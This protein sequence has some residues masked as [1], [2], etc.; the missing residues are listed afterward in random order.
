MPILKIWKNDEFHLKNINLKE[1]ILENLPY[2]KSKSE[3]LIVFPSVSNLLRTEILYSSRNCKLPLEGYYR[4]TNG[5]KRI[6]IPGTILNLPDFHWYD[7]NPE[8]GKLSYIFAG[9][10]LTKLSIMNNGMDSC[11][12]Q[13][14]II[15]NAW[16]L[17][18]NI[19]ASY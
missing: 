14:P 10:E 1:K 4:I 3:L 2:M 6:K 13:N 5:V 8:E 18:Q 7:E 19:N 12:L 15:V 17:E 11:L 9:D 16:V